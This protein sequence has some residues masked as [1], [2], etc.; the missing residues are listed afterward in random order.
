MFFLFLVPPPSDLTIT[1]N[2]LSV[3]HSEIATFTCTVT[4]LTAPSITWTGPRVPSQPAVTSQGSDVYTSSLELTG[5][6]LDSIGSYTC[7]ATNQ[8]G[9]VNTTAMLTVTG[10]DFRLYHVHVPY[11]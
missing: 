10:K 11:F 4:S 1:P 9:S 3:N 2:P 6:T 8:G 7:T 5:V